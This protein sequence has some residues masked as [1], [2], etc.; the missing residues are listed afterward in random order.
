ML[1]HLD[2]VNTEGQIYQEGLSGSSEHLYFQIQQYIFNA[3][4]F[5]N[6]QYDNKN[7]LQTLKYIFKVQGKWKVG[8]ERSSDKFLG[9]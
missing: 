4:E 8:C 1:A 5:I 7:A 9:F 3:A 2:F 6:F